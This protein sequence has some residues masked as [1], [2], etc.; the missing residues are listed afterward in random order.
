MTIHQPP[1]LPGQLQLPGMAGE[2]EQ[3]ATPET[4]PAEA[5]V[6]T[7][8]MAPPAVTPPMTYAFFKVFEKRPGCD[9]YSADGQRIKLIL[10]YAWLRSLTPELAFETFMERYSRVADFDDNNLKHPADAVK[11]YCPRSKAQADKSGKSQWTA[12]EVTDIL[13]LYVDVCREA[14]AQNV[15]P[16]ALNEFLDACADA[17]KSGE[18]PPPEKPEP[19]RGGAKRS[20]RVGEPTAADPVSGIV[21][22]N[23]PLHPTRGGQRVIYSQPSE[24]GRQI[25]GVTEQVFS[26]GD[27]HYADFR[28]DSGELIAAVNATHC[29]VCNETPPAPQMVTE[30]KKLWIPKSQMPAVSQAMGLTSPMGNMAIADSIYQWEQT[31]ECGLVA[32]LTIVNGESGPYVDPA[33]IDPTTNDVVAEIEPRRSLLGNYYFNTPNGVVSLEV[34]ARQ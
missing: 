8:E 1:S 4:P 12:Q 27:R 19:K 26:E 24:G 11:Y 31:F 33:L 5:P 3:V 20:P 30:S 6:V 10:D 23:T 13:V 18:I 2:T 28:A 16:M 9:R 14:D 32:M 15:E 25:K 21:E 29:V 7:P 17:Y 34:C 22:N